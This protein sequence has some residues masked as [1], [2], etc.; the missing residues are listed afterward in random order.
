M[1]TSRFN[2]QRIIKIR[3]QRKSIGNECD[4]EIKLK[5]GNEFIDRTLLWSGASSGLSHYGQPIKEAGDLE[6]NSLYI[7]V[8]AFPELD[9]VESFSVC[10]NYFRELLLINLYKP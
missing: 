3:K 7:R 2:W 6:G 8:L 1:Q 9:P 5:L 4:K 10:P